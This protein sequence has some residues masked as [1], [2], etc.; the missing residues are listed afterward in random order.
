MGGEK[1]QT[2]AFQDYLHLI[3]DPTGQEVPYQA[4]LCSA[5]LQNIP[6][7]KWKDLDSSPG[8]VWYLLY[9]FGSIWKVLDH[10]ENGDNSHVPIW[11]M[12]ILTVR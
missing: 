2:S 10:L 4:E 12:G 6:G 1:A 3:P 7:L 11:K 5:Q 9:T 8:I